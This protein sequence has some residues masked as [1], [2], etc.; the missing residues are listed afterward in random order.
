MF[1]GF[2]N[3]P[4]SGKS[5]PYLGMNHLADVSDIFFFCLGGARGSPRRQEGGGRFFMEIPGGG[6]PRRAGKG[7]VSVGIWGRGGLNTFF[8]GPKFPP[9]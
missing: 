9:S 3:F 6:S 5:Q 2:Q 1:P 4:S 8:S 7:R